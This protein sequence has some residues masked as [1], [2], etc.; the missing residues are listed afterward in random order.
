[1][2]ISFLYAGFAFVI[3]LIREVVKDMEDMEGDRR[4]DC[5]TMPIVWG[6]NVSKMFVAVWIIVLILVLLALQFYV[7]QFHWWLSALWCVALIIVPLIW[8]FKKLFKAQTP[9]DFHILSTAIKLVMFTGILSMFFFWF[10]S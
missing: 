7:L 2:R 4:Y 1:M 9:G 5:R 8:I 6:L 10:Y 3:S